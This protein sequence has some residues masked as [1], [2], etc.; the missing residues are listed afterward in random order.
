MVDA[1]EGQQILNKRMHLAHT[2]IKSCEF[3]LVGYVLGDCGNRQVDHVQRPAQVVRHT[4]SKSV[5]FPVSRFEK[6]CRM[7]DLVVLTNHKTGNFPCKERRKRNDAQR[8]GTEQQQPSPLKQC[9][10]MDRIVRRSSI[11]VDQ[12][13]RLAI[14]GIKA[15]CEALHC[16]EG[17]WVLI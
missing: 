14:D 15:C 2:A 9:D 11:D 13:I 4:S 6:L 12:A 3:L 8:D 5:K 7:N 1:R 17:L 10:L 16:S